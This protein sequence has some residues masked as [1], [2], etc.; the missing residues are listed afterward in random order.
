VDLESFIVAT[1]VWID[2]ALDGW[3]A[4]AGPLRTR[5]PAPTLADSEVLTME[6]VGEF[7][8][9]DGD[10]AILAYFRRHHTA[11][12]P[13]IGRVHRTTFARQ[14]SNLWAAKEALWPRAV[15][16]LP[17]DPALAIVDSLPLP[18]C[19]LAHAKRCRRLRAEAAFGRDAT[20]RSFF[21][22]LRVHLRVQWPGVITAV[23]AAPANRSDLEVLPELVDGLVGVVLADRNY[24]NP[25]VRDELAGE[26]VELLAPYRHR[27]EDPTP[28]RSK[29][30]NRVRRQV[31]TVA[32]QLVERFNLKRVWARDAWHLTNRLLRKVLSHTLAIRLNVALGADEPRQLARLIA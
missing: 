24:W 12:F 10:S 23:S 2:D 25:K 22:G 15:A 20:S 21:Y 1:F 18:V 32:S 11:L 26:G 17:C 7:L 28:Q 9:I 30:L 14:A 29:L 16:E 4:E 8:G 19:R 6:V 5:G 31:E 3:V 13:N 27:S